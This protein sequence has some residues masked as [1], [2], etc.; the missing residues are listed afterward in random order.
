MKD[1]PDIFQ[2]GRFVA[3][4]RN[5]PAIAPERRCTEVVGESRNVD[6]ATPNE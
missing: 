3:V 4:R 1:A 6:G 5:Q 2:S